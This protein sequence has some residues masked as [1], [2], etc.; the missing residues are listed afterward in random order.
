MSCK[1]IVLLSILSVVCQ[2]IPLLKTPLQYAEDFANSL[3]I[4]TISFDPS[5]LENSINNTEFIRFREF[6]EVT[7]PLVHLN[8]ERTIVNQYS[9]LFKWTGSNSTLKPIFINGH[10][11]VVPAK[12][13][14]DWWYDPFNGTINNNYIYGRGAI[15]NKVIVMS[16]LASVEAM[17]AS[18]YTPIRTVFLAFGHDEELG[19]N[20]G[21]KKISQYVQSLNITAEMLIDEGSPLLKEGFLRGVNQDT[22][23]VGVNEKGYIFYNL[24]VVTQPGHSAMPPAETA[25]GIISKAAL[26][27]EKNPFPNVPLSV[28]NSEFLNLFNYSDIESQPYL[29]SMLKTTTAVTMIKAGVKS[30][31]I[32][33]QATVWVNHRIIAG[34]NVSYTLQRIY[35]LVNDSRITLTIDGTMEPSPV[36]PIAANPY[37]LLKS[38]LKNVYGSNLQV[39]SGQM[40]GN[41]DTRHY[42]NLTPNIYRMMPLKCNYDEFS[43][44]HGY[45]EKITIDQF[46]QAIQFYKKLILKFQLCDTGSTNPV[47]SDPD[48]QDTDC[49]GI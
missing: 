12:F 20:Q 19:G 15:D 44:L 10:F 8:L 38:A 46:Y 27:L 30:N 35:E 2:C 5:D 47:S 6:L 34:S 11:D 21:H 24:S 22:A 37:K 23:L 33:N 40:F 3:K 45:N 17:L 26:A 42:W 18:N 25:I 14:P 1:L 7:F 4:K 28:I 41:T 9:L 16:S 39:V 43:T 29:S 13:T 31:V 49:G 36:S 48:L 32:A